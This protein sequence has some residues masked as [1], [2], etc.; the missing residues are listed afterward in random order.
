MHH[1]YQLRPCRA[2]RASI[3]SR[4]SRRCPHSRAQTDLPVRNHRQPFRQIF[5]EQPPRQTRLELAQPQRAQDV[6]TIIAKS[7]RRRP[8]AAPLAVTPPTSSKQKPR[9]IIAVAI[10]MST[11]SAP[12]VPVADGLWTEAEVAAF[13]KVSRSWVYHRVGGLVRF[14]PSTIRAHVSAGSSSHAT[15]GASATIRSVR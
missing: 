12:E 14:D 10:T 4:L 3:L 7:A 6:E 8:H 11:I 1:A 5:I 2:G 9:V 15:R 13:L